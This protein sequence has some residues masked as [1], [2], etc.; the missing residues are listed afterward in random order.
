M[1]KLT[2]SVPK[3]RKHRASG[4]AIVTIGGKDFYLGPHGTKASH[5]EYDRVITEW[6]A[7]GRPSTWPPPGAADVTI[8]ELI[9]DYFNWAKV[10]Y[11]DKNGESTGTA[12]LLKPVFKRF[13]ELYGRTLVADFRPHCLEAMQ[14]KWIEMGHSRRYINMNTQRIKQMFK[15]GVKKDLVPP[16]VWHRIKEVSGL[17][18][19]RTKARETAPVE[20]VADEVVD[21]TLL[22]LSSVVADMVRFQRLAGCRPTETCIV[23]PCD[24]DRSGDVWRY[25]PES[26]KT[27]Y[28]GRG[29]MIFIGPQAQEILRPYLLRESTAFCFSPADSE[30]KRREEC[31]RRRKTPLSCGNRPGTN[32]KRNP[33]RTIGERY[34]KD[35]Y[36][37]AIRRAIDKANE[38]RA[39]NELEPLPIWTPGRLR[40]SAGTEIRRRYG[41]EAAQVVLGH[42]SA[43]VT[44]VYAERD[45]AK[46]EEIM[47]EVG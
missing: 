17:A 34:T 32:R 33:K 1:P 31:H 5:L 4:Q 38:E 22:H 21:T 44:Q 16:D 35:S 12:E 39:K 25:V 42:A 7:A 30:R 40:H 41:L 29:R 13:R 20:P 14:R 2:S 8:S 37:R 47:R 26:H 24:I 23:R 10:Y 11:R 36:N 46:A 3:Y 27:E 28:R 15:W 43:D 9:R 19:G 45:L 6:L 18:R